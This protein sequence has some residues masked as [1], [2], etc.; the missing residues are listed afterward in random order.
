MT[1]DNNT[2]VYFDS[3]IK[4]AIEVFKNDGRIILENHASNIKCGQ[5]N[6]I[7]VTISDIDGVKI[8][9]FRH[10]TEK[11]TTFRSGGGTSPSDYTT[12]CTGIKLISEPFI[13]RN[14][15]LQ[16]TVNVNGNNLETFTYISPQTQYNINISCPY[17][18][19]SGSTPAPITCSSNIDWVYP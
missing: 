13:P 17:H 19:P 1:V 16:V 8:G 14:A 7:L 5:K 15:E 6:N 11:S 12:Y 10:N 2:I 4:K 18:L 9:D 3:D